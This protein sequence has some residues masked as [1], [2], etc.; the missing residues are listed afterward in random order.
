MAQLFFK[1]RLREELEEMNAV[2]LKKKKPEVVTSN[3]K[4]RGTS[5]AFRDKSRTA[6]PPGKRISKT[7]KTYWETRANR[8]D[9][10][11][12]KL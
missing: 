9:A 2:G 5:N 6:L 8:S 12:S 7:G 11:G 10:V 3:L 1:E 4:Q